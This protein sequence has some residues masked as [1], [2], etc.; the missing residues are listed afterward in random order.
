MFPTMLNRLI[1]TIFVVLMWSTGILV[2]ASAASEEPRAVVERLNATL[3]QV[4]MNAQRLG[5]QG[6]ADM[7]A[8]VLEKTFAFPGMVRI[9]VG[10]HWNTLDPDQKARLVERFT[11][12][13]IATFANRF[14]GYSGERFEIIGG[15]AAPRDRYLVRSDIVKPSGETVPLNYVF[16]RIDGDW[17]I[18]DVYLKGTIS[19]LATRR[20]EFVSVLG[21]QGFDELMRRIEK[22]IAALKG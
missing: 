10:Q 6:R 18:V 13:S 8:P 7:L 11:Q 17:R 15:E 3:L 9:A 22:N 2:N 12:M 5:F 20:S 4:M 16:T 1:L 19:E 14:D 21:R